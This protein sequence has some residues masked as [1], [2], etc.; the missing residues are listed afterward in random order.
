MRIR[1]RVGHGTVVSVRLP[2]QPPAPAL[3]P[4]RQSA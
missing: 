3:E 4:L 2:S 1:S